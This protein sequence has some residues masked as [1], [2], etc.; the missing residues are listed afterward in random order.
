[1]DSEDNEKKLEE[2]HNRSIEKG[3]KLYFEICDLIDKHRKSWEDDINVLTAIEFA[4]T[5]SSSLHYGEISEVCGKEFAHELIDNL[6]TYLHEMV[7]E[8]IDSE[9]EDK[10]Q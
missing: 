8:G 10:V 3:D 7:E 2:I 5:T 4:I 6:S 1:M 9:P